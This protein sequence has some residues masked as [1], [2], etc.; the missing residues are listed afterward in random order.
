M[1]VWLSSVTAYRVFAAKNYLLYMDL[2]NE[3][4]SNNYI[5]LASIIV[6]YVCERRQQHREQQQYSYFHGT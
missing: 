1:Y 3:F 6:Y 2:A 5:T 4:E